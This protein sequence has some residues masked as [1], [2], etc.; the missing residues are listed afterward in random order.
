MIYSV[1]SI[2][3][4]WDVNFLRSFCL[5]GVRMC[6]VSKLGKYEYVGKDNFH[7]SIR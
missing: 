4:F 1:S 3:S 6:S 7:K 5:Y 2:A